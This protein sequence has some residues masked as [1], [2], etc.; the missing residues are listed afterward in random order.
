MRLTASIG[1]TDSD[2]IADDH[3]VRHEHGR[4]GRAVQL[5][6]DRRRSPAAG[7]RSPTLPRPV[8]GRRTSRWSPSRAT[9]QDLLDSFLWGLSESS[10][11]LQLGHR[12]PVHRRGHVRARRCPR[13]ARAAG[14]R[15]DPHLP[16]HDVG[17][18]HVHRRRPRPRAC[19]PADRNPE[20]VARWH[21]DDSTIVVRS[22]MPL[23][24]L[25][26]L[27]P[28]L[29]RTDD[30]EWRVVKRRAES[31][32]DRDRSTSPRGRHRDRQRDAR[33]G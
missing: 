30:S 9:D 8:A 18:G 10:H 17:A 29:R 3:L 28:T 23:G 14:D 12:R 25:L 13:A 31:R 22:N 20:I 16:R 24:E 32:A 33:V 6:R 1:E 5:D 7:R 15:T 26:E 2:Q 19:R 27:L 4:T 21:T 11:V